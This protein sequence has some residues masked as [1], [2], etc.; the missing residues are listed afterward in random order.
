MYYTMETIII[1]HLLSCTEKLGV[2]PNVRNSI[3]KR[4]ILGFLPTAHDD[5]G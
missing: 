3:G 4:L 2:T 1:R 5:L